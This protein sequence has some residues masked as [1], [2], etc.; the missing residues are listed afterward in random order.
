M[1]YHKMVMIR[2]YLAL[3][4]F[5]FSCSCAAQKSIQKAG[6]F[7]SGY[8]FENGKDGYRCFRIPAVV[9]TKRG[10]IIAISEARKDGCSDTGN[11]DLVMK[12]SKDGGKTWGKLEVIWDDGPNTCGNPSPVVD[13]TTGDIFLLST[14]NLGSDPEPKIIEQTSQDTRRVF[15][16]KSEDDGVT[17][18]KPDEITKDVKLSDWTWYATGPGSGIQIRGGEFKNRLV[19]ACDHIEAH[20]KKYYSHVIYSD[21]HGK[22]WHLGGS[23]PKDQVN[24]CEVVELSDNSLMLNMRNYDRSKN[25]RQI[26]YSMD[27]GNSWENM[28]HHE[29]LIEPIC[30]AST[31]HMDFRNQDMLLFLNPAD[32]KKRINMT[33]K[34]SMDD[35]KT[36]PITKSIHPG[37]SA[38]SDLTKINKR[39]VGLLYEAGNEN[40]YEGIVWETVNLKDL[41][42]SKK[43]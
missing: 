37:P 20:T 1:I 38:Y 23:T 29:S 40:P 43:E 17:W 21:D 25:T 14:W 4:F 13:R 27:G 11:I 6:T 2:I 12:R 19:I 34:L 15:V 28:K 3:F 5:S 30:Q 32:K 9:T 7:E 18:S 36:W 41:L 22:S 10:T 31:L 16:M 33:L 39:Q 35:G 8:L 24:E 42:P 26:A